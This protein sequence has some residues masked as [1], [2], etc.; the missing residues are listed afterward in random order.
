MSMT[1]A[2]RKALL[3]SWIKPS[4]NDEVLQQERA[5]RMVRA[6]VDNCNALKGV[7]RSIYAKG[8]YAN[9]TNVRRDSDV[10]IVVQCTECLYYDYIHSAPPSTSSSTPYQGIWTP[11]L[12]R[13]TIQAALESSFGASDVDSSGSVAINVAPVQGSRPSIDVVPSFDYRRYDSSDRTSSHIGSCVFPKS[14]A[15]IVNW[16]DQQ[17]TNGR[18]KNDR[19]GKRYKN[20][21]RALKNSENYLVSQGTLK[22]TPSYLMECI[23]WNMADATLGS[24]DLDGGFRATLVEG[25]SAMKDG[26]GW[27]DWKEPNELKWLFRGGQK[28]SVADAREVVLETW[29][30]LDY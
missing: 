9:N 19:T 12:W 20:Y 27:N 4:S 6:A 1:A 24:G 11:T 10:D 8:S 14:G 23:I 15:K 3:T 29:K 25:W 5:V 28:W 16:P 22:A 26:G 7:G 21:V 13:S 17:L 2:E 18:R 30:M